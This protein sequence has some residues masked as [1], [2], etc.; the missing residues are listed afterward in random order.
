MP[1]QTTEE[2][3]D[4]VARRVI[5]DRL[6][7]P[8]DFWD[9]YPEIGE[10]DWLAVCNRVRELANAGAPHVGEYESAYALL[11]S[12]ADSGVVSDA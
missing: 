3:I 7:E 8:F 11:E 9:G 1:E 10:D 2:A 4:I 6:D 5:N 12:R